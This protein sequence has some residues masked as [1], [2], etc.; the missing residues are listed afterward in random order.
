MT[1]PESLGTLTEKPPPAVR[2]DLAVVEGRR[3]AHLAALAEEGLA[4]LAPPPS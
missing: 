4:H 3:R 1:S 2:A